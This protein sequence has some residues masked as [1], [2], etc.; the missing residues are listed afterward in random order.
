[1]ELNRIQKINMNKQQNPAKASEEEQIKIQGIE[2]VVDDDGQVQSSD[3]G[4]LGSL[5]S[6]IQMA[7]IFSTLAEVTDEIDLT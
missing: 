4:P 2:F 7:E 5:E 3:I 1:M 6:C